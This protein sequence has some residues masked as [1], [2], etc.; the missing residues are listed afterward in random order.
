MNKTFISLSSL[1]MDLERVAI[2]YQR[3]SIRM[4]ERFLKEAFARRNEIDKEAVKPYIRKIL[5]TLDKINIEK[6]IMRKAEDALM[7]S[8]L[9][10]NASIVG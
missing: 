9:F 4:A 7:Y 6:D 8:I 1:S 3:G 2:G 5:N 10:Q